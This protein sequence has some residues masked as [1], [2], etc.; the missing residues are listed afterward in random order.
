[1][2]EEFCNTKVNKKFAIER[3]KLIQTKEYSCL[4]KVRLEPHQHT[5][6]IFTVASI[7]A[8]QE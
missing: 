7:G 5:K 2:F 3:L 1:M 4:V 6:L 8:R